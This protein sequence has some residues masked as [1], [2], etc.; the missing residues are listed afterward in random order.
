LRTLSCTEIAIA[1]KSN[2]GITIRLL[3][4]QSP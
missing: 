4:F 1:V 2:F 3:Y